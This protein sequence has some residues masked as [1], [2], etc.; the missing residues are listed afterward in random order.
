MSNSASESVN[1]DVNGASTASKRLQ[2]TLP[3][4]PTMPKT[5]YH[6]TGYRPRHV[7]SVPRPRAVPFIALSKALDSSF[8][9]YYQIRPSP[10]AQIPVPVIYQEYKPAVACYDLYSPSYK[11]PKGL[12]AGAGT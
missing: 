3:P 9:Q 5:Q 11:R 4:R 7:P 12:G 8:V 2:W 6:V 1:L 10:S